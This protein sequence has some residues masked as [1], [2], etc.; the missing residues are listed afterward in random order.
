M[1]VAYKVQGLLYTA[2][3]Q[4]LRLD[5]GHS[6]DT[7]ADWHLR[8]DAQSKSGIKSYTNSDKH[9]AQVAH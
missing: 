4:Y 6:Y 3:G 9:G 5:K 2:C 1:V 7:W 8:G